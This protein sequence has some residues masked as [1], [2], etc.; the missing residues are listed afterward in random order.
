MVVCEPGLN[1][2]KIF[3]FKVINNLN[4]FKDIADLI[5]ANRKVGCL[6]YLENKCFFRDIFNIN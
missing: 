2:S 1:A 6:K 5:V 4:K 3:G